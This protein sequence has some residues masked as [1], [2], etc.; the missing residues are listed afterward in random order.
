LL[1][2]YLAKIDIEKML[3]GMALAWSV[4]TLTHVA[5]DFL[6]DVEL[7]PQL[8]Q[9]SRPAQNYLRSWIVSIALYH[10]PP[11]A[12]EPGDIVGEADAE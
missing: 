5:F 10:H 9:V 11:Q 4:L 1:P 6:W 2:K 7:G 12:I 3:V 8:A